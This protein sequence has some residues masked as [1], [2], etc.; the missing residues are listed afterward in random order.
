MRNLIQILGL[1]QLY[2]GP[3]LEE[4]ARKAA[5]NIDRALNDLGLPRSETLNLT[6]ANL[7]RTIIFCDDSGSMS[8]GGLFHQTLKETVKRL[9]PLATRLNEDSVSLRFINFNGDSKMDQVRENKIDEILDGIKPFGGTM[10]GAALDR[11]VVQPLLDILKDG[12]ALKPLLVSIITDGEVRMPLWF[13]LVLCRL[14]Y[15]NRD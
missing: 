2:T 4:F 8:N 9:V 14:L 1:D 7:F 5:K 6:K 3:M 11:K 12:N 10:I 13:Q 15:Q